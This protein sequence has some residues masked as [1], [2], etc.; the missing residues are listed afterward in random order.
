MLVKGRYKL[1]YYQGYDELGEN[2]ERVDLFDLESD[3]EELQNL[4]PSGEGD[5]GALLEELKAKISE[6]DAPF[7]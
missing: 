6:V 5:A 7:R 1:V 2:G 3:P 4:Y